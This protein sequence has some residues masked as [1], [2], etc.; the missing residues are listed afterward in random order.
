MKKKIILLLFIMILAVSC[1]KKVTMSNYKKEANF[2]GIVKEVNAH[3]L[4]VSV[5][6]TED[7]FKTSDLISVSLDIELKDSLVTFNI[8][9]EIRIYYDGIIADSYPAQIN[10]VY[11]IDIIKSSNQDKE[12]KKGD[13][14]SMQWDL[15]P[16]V[17]LNNKLYLDTGYEALVN[18]KAHLIDGE[19]ISEV[20]GNKKP[21]VNNQS[22][23]GKGYSYRYGEINGTIEISINNKWWIFAT[24][25]VRE[26]I[27]KL[28]NQN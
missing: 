18:D 24:E 10:K 20:D 4:L 13:D 23:F 15:V 5:D 22:N 9:D 25:E 11:A 3:S 1:T 14:Y 7:E 16:M 21:T 6:K 26:D 8:G 17:R 28:L 19:I 12:N 2:S 27:E